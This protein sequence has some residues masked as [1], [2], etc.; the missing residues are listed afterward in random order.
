MKSTLTKRRAGVVVS[1]SASEFEVNYARS[2]SKLF[3]GTTNFFR[4]KNP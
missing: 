2:T 4:A 3:F 1:A